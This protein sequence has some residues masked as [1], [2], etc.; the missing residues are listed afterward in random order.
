MRRAALLLISGL[1]WW[2]E[3]PGP[4][5][6]EWLAPAQTLRPYA[7]VVTTE[8]SC[9]PRTPDSATGHFPNRHLKSSRAFIISDLLSSY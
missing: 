7:A 3:R 4:I 2:F 9:W 6:D 5:F 1:A 8:I